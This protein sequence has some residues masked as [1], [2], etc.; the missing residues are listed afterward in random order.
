MKSPLS[1]KVRLRQPYSQRTP[2]GKITILRHLSVN[3][4]GTVF[5]VSIITGSSTEQGTATLA[6]M[7]RRKQKLHLN[8]TS[9]ICLTHGLTRKDIRDTTAI[10]RHDS[11]YRRPSSFIN[12]V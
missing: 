11:I 12:K 2:V 3:R 9:V 7:T 8:R 4:A 6:G 10:I 5:H 1:P